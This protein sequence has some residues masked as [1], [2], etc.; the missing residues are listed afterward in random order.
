MTRF[1]KFLLGLM[2]SLGLAAVTV[3]HAQPAAAWSWS[4]TVTIQGKLTG[5]TFAQT[6]SV[7]GVLNGQNQSYNAPLG[8]PPSYHLTFSNVPG[9][10]SWAWVVVDC[11]VSPN[12]GVW[13]HMYRPGWGSTINVNL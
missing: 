13:V 8:Q 12:Y 5:C 10:Y 2:L 7:H 9:G 6:A 4:S 3:Q 1:H 11:T